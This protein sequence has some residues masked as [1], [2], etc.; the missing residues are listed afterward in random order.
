MLA[1]LVTAQGDPIGQPITAEFA[2]L[3]ACEAQ[4]KATVEALALVF[5]ERTGPI[6]LQSAPVNAVKRGSGVWMVEFQRQ[7][8]TDPKIGEAA[9]SRNVRGVC[10]ELGN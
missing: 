10:R 3:A 2:N 5:E 1:A 9:Q 6:R 4:V 7:S 8:R